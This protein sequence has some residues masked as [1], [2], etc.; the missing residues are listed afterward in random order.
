M[1]YAK[2]KTKQKTKNVFND[3]TFEKISNQISRVQDGLSTY[4]AFQSHMNCFLFYVT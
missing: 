2:N 1:N 3:I 4:A